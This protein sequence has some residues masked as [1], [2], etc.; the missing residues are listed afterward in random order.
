MVPR[1]EQANAQRMEIRLVARDHR[2]VIF[3]RRSRQQSIKTGQGR[4][5]RRADWPRPSLRDGI[6]DVQNPVSKPRIEI[7]LEP[8]LEI[9]A[10][11]SIRNRSIPKRISAR[12][13]TLT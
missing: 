9:S 4:P 11:P 10:P 2:E 13:M 12:V 8:A 1:I 7:D 3:S 5:R 6:G